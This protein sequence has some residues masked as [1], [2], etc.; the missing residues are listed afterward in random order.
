MM[1]KFITAAVLAT[2]LAGAAFVDAGW[3]YNSN[4][5]RWH[6]SDRPTRQSD[7]NRSW[8]EVEADARRVQNPRLR[9]ELLN[10]IARTKNI[11]AEILARLRARS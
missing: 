11:E 1:K 6:Q 10:D 8:S 7:L 2:G 4:Q 3:R 5:E 9:Q